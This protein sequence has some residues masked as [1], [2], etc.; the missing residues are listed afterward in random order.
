[1]FAYNFSGART[2]IVFVWKNKRINMPCRVA[3]S[4]KIPFPKDTVVKFNEKYF[5]M[6]LEMYLFLQR[7]ILK[8]PKHFEIRQMLQLAI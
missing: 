2:V 5:D 1:M 4:Y 3:C 8:N 7:K 6:L